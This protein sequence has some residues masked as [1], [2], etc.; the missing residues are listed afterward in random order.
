MA[1][2]AFVVSSL[3]ASN[4]EGQRRYPATVCRKYL[5]SVRERVGS[6]QYGHGVTE[7]LIEIE[8]VS[9]WQSGTLYRATCDCEEWQGAWHED[10]SHAEAEGG[11]HILRSRGTAQAVVNEIRATL[12]GDRKV[13]FVR[14]TDTAVPGS[15]VG[16]PMPTSADEVE[17]LVHPNDWHLLASESLSGTK[18]TQTDSIFGVPVLYDES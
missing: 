13:S 17:I 6:A 14:V 3:A 16:V 18:A 10:S 7:H 9:T 4:W 15:V 5:W 2:A 12:N 11:A 8:T 1:A